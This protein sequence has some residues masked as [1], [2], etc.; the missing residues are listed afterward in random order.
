MQYKEICVNLSVYKIVSIEHKNSTVA[1]R[2]LELDGRQESERYI[3]KLTLNIFSYRLMMYE[4]FYIIFNNC[5]GD[6]SE[7]QYWQSFDI[8]VRNLF[9]KNDVIPHGTE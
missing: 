6:P 8:F 5:T 4:L 9:Q 2:Y 3:C 1:P 7:H